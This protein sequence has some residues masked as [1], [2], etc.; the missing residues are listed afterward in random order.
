MRDHHAVKI[1]SER[2]DKTLYIDT[3]IYQLMLNIW[4]LDLTTFFSC[5]NKH[6]S[7]YCEIGFNAM[8]AKKFLNVISKYS[9]EYPELFKQMTDQDTSDNWKIDVRLR[10]KKEDVGHHVMFVIGIMFP[11]KHIKH[12]EEITRRHLK[13]YGLV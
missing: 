2:L 1:Y 10:G 6:N 4:E 5:Q 11:T 13:E 3:E 12:V 7:G 8:T 9:D